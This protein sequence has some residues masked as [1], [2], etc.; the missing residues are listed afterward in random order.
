MSP[1]A[2]AGL[3]SHTHWPSTMDHQVRNLKHLGSGQDPS[4][5]K[6]ETTPTKDFSRDLG[7]G[8][9]KQKMKVRL[10]RKRRNKSK[11]FLSPRPS[12][13]VSL[14]VYKVLYSS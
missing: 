8:D 10:C 7:E 1:G 11:K 14:M 5:G 6:P 13:T 2:Q 9:H 12:H 4:T 3:A